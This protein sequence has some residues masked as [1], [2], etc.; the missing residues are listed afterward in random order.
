M[1]TDEKTT[2]TRLSTARSRELGEELR[3]VRHAAGL[4]S[5]EVAESLGWSLGKLSKLETGSRGTSQWEIAIMVGRCGADKATR[6][7]VMA[8]VHEPDTGSFTRSHHGSPDTLTALTVH[9]RLAGDVVAYE[10]LTVPAL[11]QTAAYAR[12]LTGDEN[13][14]SVRAAR[15]DRL[16]HSRTPP[17]I[18]LYVHETALRLVVGDRAV[19]RD[20]LLHLAL[21]IG[22]PDVTV[23]VIP[24]TAS[25]HP[26]LRHHATL[27]TFAP[28]LPPLAYSESGLAT[29]FHDHPDAIEHYRHRMRELHARALPEAQ[30]GQVIARWADVYDKGIR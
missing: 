29:V 7:R 11:A 5:A 22:R 26:A 21:L 25:P 27:L 10:P 19:M 13:L 28:P 20:Q 1:D 18:T 12:A 24:M 6:D 8:I 9:E 4:S 17:H 30:S 2:Q 23:H 14:T 3:R 16:L 15:L